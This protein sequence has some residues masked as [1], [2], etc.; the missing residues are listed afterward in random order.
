M[1]ELRLKES[2]NC[3]INLFLIPLGWLKRIQNNLHPHRHFQPLVWTFNI[4][5]L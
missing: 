1:E 4:D 3:F 2:P 5:Q